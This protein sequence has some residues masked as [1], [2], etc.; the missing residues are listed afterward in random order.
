M[1]ECVPSIGSEDRAAT[2]PLIANDSSLCRMLAILPESSH[3]INNKLA[4][5]M[6]KKI[7]IQR[8]DHLPS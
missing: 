6:H 3:D 7:A 5:I 1:I 4:Q 8:F 2:L